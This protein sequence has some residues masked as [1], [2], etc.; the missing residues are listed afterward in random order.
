VVGSERESPIIYDHGRLG[1]LEK[2]CAKAHRST[3]HTLR[4]RPEVVGKSILDPE[5]RTHHS[6]SSGSELPTHPSTDCAVCDADRCPG[7]SRILRR[8]CPMGARTAAVAL[9]DK[10]C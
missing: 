6:R 5:Y 1:P 10:T 4:K 3:L 7:H 9:D 2:R 8:G